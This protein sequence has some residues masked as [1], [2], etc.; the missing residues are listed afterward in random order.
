[1][2]P[3]PPVK[4]TPK[5][6]TERKVVT[7]AAGFVLTNSIVL[8]ADTE[9]A[10]GDYKFRTPKLIVHPDTDGPAPVKVV[11][12]GAGDGPFIDKLVG[13]MWHSAEKSHATDIDAVVEE[14]EDALI[15]AHQRLWP[16][17]PPNEHERPQANIL[18]GVACAGAVKLFKAS[19][20]IVNPISEYDIT[21]IAY[22]LARYIAQRSYKKNLTASQAVTLASYIL[23]QT[24]Q[25]VDG[26]GGE[27]HVVVLLKS[28]AHVKMSMEYLVALDLALSAIDPM[29]MDF[30]VAAFD[31]ALKEEELEIKLKDFTERVTQVLKVK[32]RIVADMYKLILRKMLGMEGIEPPLNSDSQEIKDQ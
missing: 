24:K 27:S 7:I 2:N 22:P 8:C 17:Y 6:L 30:L 18:F 15:A 12:A 11:F 14:M 20:P 13:E 19:G 16:L 28:G 29:V 4:F 5:R 25:Y 23:A 3:K 1:L 26:C 21:G 31:P 9:S 10:V 32:R